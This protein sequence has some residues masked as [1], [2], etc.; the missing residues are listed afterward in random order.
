MTVDN[1]LLMRVLKA[2]LKFWSGLMFTKTCVYVLYFACGFRY[3][4]QQRYDRRPDTS[5]DYNWHSATADRRSY[6]TAATSSRPNYNQVNKAMAW[7]I[8]FCVR[9]VA[10]CILVSVAYCYSS[11]L[12]E[13]D[14]S[15]TF[16]LILVR[17]DARPE[18]QSSV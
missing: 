6:P 14:L 15:A 18:I 1:Y 16:V 12:L 7:N 3:L 17:W 4:Q 8:F 2:W 10:E 9:R 11:T 13:R 5:R